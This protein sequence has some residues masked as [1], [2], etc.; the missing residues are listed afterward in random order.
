M[1][2]GEGRDL[3]I[4]ECTASERERNCQAGSTGANC[5]NILKEMKNCE[6]SCI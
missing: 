2:E 6:I 1:A 3:G 4:P 5:K